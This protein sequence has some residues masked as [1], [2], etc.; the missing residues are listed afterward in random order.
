MSMF[1]R[2]PAALL[3]VD[4]GSSSIKVVE[5]SLAAGQF[6]LE[7][8]ALEPLHRGWVVGGSVEHQA[9]VVQAL[10][11]A[12]LRSGSKLE[13]AALALPAAAVLT[14]RI[15]L[16]SSLTEQERELQVEVEAANYMPYPLDEVSLDFCPTGAAVSARGEQELLIAASRCDRVQQCVALAQAAGL[17]AQVVEVQ[18]QVACLACSR[19]LA[20]WN[21]AAERIALFEIGSQTTRLSV[22]RDG[23]LLYEREQHVGADQLFEALADRCRC[24]PEQA[25]QMVQAGSW[26]EAVVQT[27]LSPFR[28]SL[29]QELARMLGFYVSSTAWGP[30]DQ[31]LLAGGGAGLPGLEAA[32]M[33]ACTLP[34]RCVQPFDGMQ[35]G[36]DLDPEQLPQQA[37]Y[38]TACG[39]ALRG[40]VQ[41]EDGCSPT[42]PPW[43]R[44]GKVVPEPL[45]RAAAVRERGLARWRAWARRLRRPH[46]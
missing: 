41:P 22:L 13:Q 25:Q 19:L 36:G 35:W 14:R 7:H 42:V 3:G 37:V 6:T 21:T 23:E 38:L 28:F 30:V 43:R 39:L 8:C 2:A 24:G 11:R 9:E 27:V 26:P 5:L 17:R 10:Q 20:L 46:A 34:C 4:I 45:K 33:Q 16:P 32:V 29:A 18:P 40:F 31:I 1:A 44:G 12:L 15:V